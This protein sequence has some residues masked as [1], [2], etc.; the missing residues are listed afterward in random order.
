MRRAIHSSARLDAE[1]PRDTILEKASSPTGER[2][3]LWA[4]YRPRGTVESCQATEG[5]DGTRKVCLA[6]RVSLVETRLFLCSCLSQT[7]A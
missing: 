7:R 6:R 4:L 1:S 3:K 2:A 5:M